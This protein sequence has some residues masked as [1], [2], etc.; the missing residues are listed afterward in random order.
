MFQLLQH[1]F[2]QN[3][4][5]AGTVVAIVSGVIGY[6]VVLRA[7]AFASHA[8]SSI[9]FAGAT[10]AALLGVNSLIG[11]FVLV[12]LSAFGIGVLGKRIQGR[13]IEVGMVLAF[14]LGLGV[15]FISIYTNS[16][17][18][19]VG[20]LFGSILSVA[21][22]NVV[23]ITVMSILVLL[24]LSILFRPLLF[25]SIDPE[26]AEARGVPTQFL[27]VVFMLI[28]A[29]TVAVA[30]QVVGT[31]LIFAL[32]IVPAATALHLT[33]KSGTAILLSVLLGLSFTWGGLIMAFLTPL[34]VSFYISG[35]AAVTYF[36]TTTLSHTLAPHRYIS[37]EHPGKEL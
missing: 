30:V 32:I 20:V 37:S 11:T 4:I 26:I 2:I 33:N 34:P 5:L 16:A 31:L 36:L 21:R 25:S 1:E 19:T 29:A 35:L 17:T 9:G 27:S 12:L 23:I 15:L 24:A 6:F 7:Q 3:A 13:D 18:E 10:G 14:A 22:T 28:L 8:L